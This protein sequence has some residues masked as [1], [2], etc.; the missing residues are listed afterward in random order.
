MAANLS[1]TRDHLNAADKGDL[2]NPQQSAGFIVD[3]A[4]SPV[5]ASLHTQPM[6][7]D[8]TPSSDPELF[9]PSTRHLNDHYHPEAKLSKKKR[10]K[11]FGLGATPLPASH[12]VHVGGDSFARHDKEAHERAERR[13]AAIGH[14]AEEEEDDEEDE[15]DV[16]EQEH[17]SHAQHHENRITGTEHGG[18]A[19]AQSKTNPSLSKDGGDGAKEGAT[20]QEAAAPSLKERAG[21]MLGSAKD[22]ASGVLASAQEKASG[23]MESVRSA[24]VVSSLLSKVGLGGSKADEASTDANANAQAKKEEEA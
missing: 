3:P 14:G 8:P 6:H 15:D 24:P 7:P 13:D 22:T 20:G 1:A 23:M 18:L 10:A 4:L 9:D 12:G 16:T 11:K 19:P 21:G 2:M 17:T 5:H